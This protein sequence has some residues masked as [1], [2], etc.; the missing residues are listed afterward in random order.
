MDDSRYGICGRFRQFLR[1]GTQSL[2]YGRP[3]Q[4]AQTRLGSTFS[5]MM[6]C[7][8]IGL[9]FRDGARRWLQVPKDRMAI[10]TAETWCKL[11]IELITRRGG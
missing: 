7:R 2:G 8:R 9:R 5:R 11:L 6:I 3:K 4:I 1:V 10:T